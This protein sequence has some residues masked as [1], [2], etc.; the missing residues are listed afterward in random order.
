MGRTLTPTASIATNKLGSVATLN[1]LLTADHW[2]SPPCPEHGLQRQRLSLLKHPEG[3]KVSFRGYG[4]MCLL[5]P[6][7]L[8]VERFLVFIDKH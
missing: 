7:Q 4:A 6:A 5:M 8:F 2:R 3:S 1:G